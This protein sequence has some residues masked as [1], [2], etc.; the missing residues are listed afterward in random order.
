LH[1]AIERALAL[2]MSKPD[3]LA[4]DIRD[5]PSRLSRR[6]RAKGL[7]VLTWTV[8]RTDDQARATAHADQIIYEN[9]H[10]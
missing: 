2:W 6:F 4:C 5:L 10:D 3:F 1:G 7:P 9:G 8:R